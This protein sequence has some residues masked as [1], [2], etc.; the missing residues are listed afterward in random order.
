MVVDDLFH[1]V[2]SKEAV[3]DSKELATVVLN[4]L[5]KDNATFLS[6]VGVLS[7]DYYTY[8]HCV[9]VC[10]YSIAIAKKLGLKGREIEDLAHAAIL[11]DIGKAHIDPI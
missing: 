6:M 3:E 5:L 1:N 9:N 7:Y 8:S 11:H 2:E 10:I 4:N